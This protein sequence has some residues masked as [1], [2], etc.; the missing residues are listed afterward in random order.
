M[1]TNPGA[2]SYAPAVSHAM[3]TTAFTLDGYR[4]VRNLGLVRGIIVRSRSIVGTIGASLQ[5]LV[6][7]NITLLTNLCE[8]TR[9]HAFD[10]MLQHA[11]E[12]GA[13]AVIGMR[14]DATEVMQGVT[15]VLAYGTAVYVDKSSN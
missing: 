13:N 3:V 6:G 15:E 4:I 14:Y 5:T 11:A 8:K 2:A 12:L 7:G 1:S 9:E 10:L